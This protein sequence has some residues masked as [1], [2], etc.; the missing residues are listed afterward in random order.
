MFLVFNVFKNLN[1]FRIE[2][3]FNYPID[4]ILMRTYL[5]VSREKRELFLKSRKSLRINMK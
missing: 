4:C 2:S 5:Y 1:K 3:R